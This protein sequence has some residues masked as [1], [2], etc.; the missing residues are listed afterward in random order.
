MTQEKWQ[1]ALTASN[2]KGAN[3]FSLELH[4]KLNSPTNAQ[5]ACRND[6]D[7]HL[8]RE[9]LYSFSHMRHQG[10]RWTSCAYW[11]WQVM[12]TLIFVGL[13]QNARNLQKIHRFPGFFFLQ[14]R[15]WFIFAYSENLLKKKTFKNHLIKINGSII[16]W[17]NASYVAF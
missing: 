4:D 1:T 10:I 16:W 11:G 12:F 17:R 5:H 2:N 14:Y 8:V 7:Q 3:G 6:S 9:W 13:C 15:D